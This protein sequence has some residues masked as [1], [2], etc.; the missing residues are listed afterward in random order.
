MLV[1]EEVM[2]TLDH[3]LVQVFLSVVD[4]GLVPL[5]LVMYPMQ[6]VLMEEVAAAELADHL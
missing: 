5:I 2:V 3:H 6:Q 4:W 1:V